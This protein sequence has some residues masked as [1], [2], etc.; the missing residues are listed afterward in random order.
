MEIWMPIVFEKC[1]ILSALKHKKYHVDG[2][3]FGGGVVFFFNI[4]WS[5]YSKSFIPAETHGSAIFED[6]ASLTLFELFVPYC[7]AT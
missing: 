2:C 5:L 4:T 1:W 3:C 6:M 7:A